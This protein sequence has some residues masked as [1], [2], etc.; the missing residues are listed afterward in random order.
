MNKNQKNVSFYFFSWFFKNC[1]LTRDSSLWL[2]NFI[3]SVRDSVIII[4]SGSVTYTFDLRFIYKRWVRVSIKIWIL[5]FL[6]KYSNIICWVSKRVDWGSNHLY[7]KNLKFNHLIEDTVI[8][9]WFSWNFVSMK[10]II[11][12][13]NSMVKVSKFT[14]NKKI[15]ENFEGFL[16][17]LVWRETFSISH[18]LTY[19]SFF[20]FFVWSK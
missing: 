11:K 14:S 20:F 13:C 19:E 8:D 17:K 3:P 2:S 10:D 5:A 12:T 4:G 9:L 15:Y 16:F 1:E 6:G 18:G 7:Y